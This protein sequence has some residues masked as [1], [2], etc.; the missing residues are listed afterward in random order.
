MRESCRKC[1]VGDSKFYLWKA[2]KL[3][4]VDDNEYPQVHNGI[5]T[6]APNS[7]SRGAKSS[8]QM[9]FIR[10]IA[11]KLPSLII[12]SFSCSRLNK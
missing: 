11:E 9:H 12:L 7:S 6:G 2:E 4:L 3:V 1:P 5:S 8:N 10:V